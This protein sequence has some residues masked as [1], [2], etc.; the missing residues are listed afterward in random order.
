MNQWAVLVLLATVA[1]S[2]CAADEAIASCIS[3]TFPV[4]LLNRSAIRSGLIVYLMLHCSVPFEITVTVPPFLNETAA[5]PES[6]VVTVSVKD[7]ENGWLKN[8]SMI[9]F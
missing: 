5:I 2:T 4:V 6:L 1:V 9:I 8:K 7:S 3:A